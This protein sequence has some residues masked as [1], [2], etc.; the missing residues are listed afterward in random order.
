MSDHWFTAWKSAAANALPSVDLAWRT[1][2]ALLDA[3]T[4]NQMDDASLRG[5]AENRLHALVKHTLH[6]SPF[7]AA[8]WKNAG[9][10]ELSSLPPVT[11]KQ[12]MHHFDDWPTDRRITRAAVDDFLQHNEALGQPF[13]GSFSVWTSSGTTGEP[14]IFVQDDEALAVYDALETVRFRGITQPTQLTRLAAEKVAMVASTGGHFAG[15]ATIERLRL[16]YP[17]LAP[18]LQTFSL[19]QPLENLVAELNEFQPTQLATY[20]T[21]AVILAEQQQAGRLNI[22]PQEIWF[23]GENLSAAQKNFV[24]KI[25]SARLRN[26]YGASEA[27]TI[28]CECAHGQLHWHNDWML[29]EPVDQNYQPVPLGEMSYTLLLTNLANRTQPLI[30]YDL[31]D[32]VRFVKQSCTCGSAFPVLEVQGRCDDLLKL[33][34]SN[35]QEMKFSPLAVVTVLEEELGLTQFQL[36]Q[37]GHNE[38]K[39]RL[40]LCDPPLRKKAP[41]VMRAWFKAQ[42]ID[43]LHFSVEQHPLQREKISGKLRRV[44]CQ[45]T[46]KEMHA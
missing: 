23:G 2:W 30:R 29:L 17:W 11:K 9:L 40:E 46:R 36:L 6:H 22:A 25:F 45:N 34:R 38:L 44:I 18:R 14:G 26:D 7:Y 24:R 35:G 31:G 19:M 32:S 21:A 5:R 37:T 33:K 4:A 10:H 13:L 16:R 42:G 12:L 39:L 43:S 28:A 20:P 41:V 27:M 1:Q 15:A 8:H 3:W